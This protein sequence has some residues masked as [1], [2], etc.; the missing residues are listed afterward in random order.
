R[1][2]AGEW[3]LLAQQAIGDF[4]LPILVGGT[5]LY[6]RA[7][8]DGIVDIPKVPDEVTRSLMNEHLAGNGAKLHGRLARIDSAYVARIH[9]NDRQRVV[10]SL[11]VFE[12]TCRNSSLWDEQ[13]PSPVDCDILRIGLKI[14]LAELERLL[15]LR[16]EKML[17]AG[18]LAEVEREWQLV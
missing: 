12:A 11:A 2:S 4:Q 15:N 18:A 1:M 10:P 8:L 3:S 17:E 16:I 5:G 6:L 9:P 7:L 13:T 14:P